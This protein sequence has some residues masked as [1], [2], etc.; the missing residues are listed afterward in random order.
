MIVKLVEKIKQTARTLAKSGFLH[1]FSS[2]VINKVI[3]FATG[4]ILVR[5]IA[6]DAYGV[7]SYSNNILGFFMLVS[8]LGASSAILQLCSEGHT[9]EDRIKFYRFGCSFGLGVNAVLGVCILL[10]AMFI[11]LPIVGSNYCLALMSFIPLCHLMSDMQTMYLRT[12]LRNRDYAYANMLI[13]FTYFVCVS[14]LSWFMQTTGLIIG[15]YIAYTFSAILIIAIYKV[16]LALGKYRLSKEDL[17][18]F[19]SISSISVI[20][21]GLSKL[22][23][24]LDIFVLGL[25]VRNETIIASYK[26]ATNIPTALLFIPASIV[27]YIYPYFARNKDN[28]DWVIRNFIRVIMYLG[29][30]NVAISGILFIFAPQF[31][32]LIFG[33]QYLDSV[34]P[35][36]ILCVGYIFSGTFRT[37]CGNL[38]ITQRKLKFNLFVSV[39]SSALNTVLN[40]FMIKAYGSN[41]AAWAT[42]IT[43]IFCSIL[44]TSYLIYTF[45]RIDGK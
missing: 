34:G 35:F 22:M 21:N 8:G 28:R 13:T 23:Y 5:I 7:Y 33:K 36:R 26:V 14:V 2:S 12:E 11:K 30:L 44:S 15:Q 18:A 27:I 25:V 42:L 3:T 38:L 40:Y 24:L 6:K 17:S 39:A 43:A 45:S 32:T 16:P 9:P 31:I 20:N 4:I 29:V 19:F 10:S 41:G 1:I 37:I